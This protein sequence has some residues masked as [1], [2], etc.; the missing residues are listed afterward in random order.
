MNWEILRKGDFHAEKNSI[1]NLKLWLSKLRNYKKRKIG[2]MI[3]WIRPSKDFLLSRPQNNI[4]DHY[5]VTNYKWKMLMRKIL[6]IILLHPIKEVT[7]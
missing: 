3:I 4:R 7:L 5:V 1:S 6:L 2:F